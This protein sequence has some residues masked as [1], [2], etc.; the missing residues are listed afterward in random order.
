MAAKPLSNAAG[1]CWNVSVDHYKRNIRKHEKHVTNWTA[2]GHYNGFVDDPSPRVK[3]KQ[4]Q[5]RLLAELL[6]GGA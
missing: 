1:G 3:R 6:K 5:E 4:A 2:G